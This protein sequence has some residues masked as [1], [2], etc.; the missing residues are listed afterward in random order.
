MTKVDLGALETLEL[1]STSTVLTGD[2]VF[3]GDVFKVAGFTKISGIVY[4]D[5]SSAASGLVIEQAADEDDFALGY[6]TRSTQSYTGAAVTSNTIQV[7]I[8]AP[9]ARIVYTNG[10]TPQTVFRLWAA[11]KMMGN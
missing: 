6:V 4:S 3:T 2:G 11:A 10:A 8:V 5:Q 9:F 1:A 7:N